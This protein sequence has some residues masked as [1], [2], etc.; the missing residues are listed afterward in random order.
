[1]SEIKFGE[2]C[3][4]DDKRDA[5]HVAVIPAIADEAL[6]PGEKVCHRYQYNVGSPRSTEER[7]N[8][9]GFVDPFLKVT[10]QAGERFWLFMS[11]S[12]VKQLRHDWKDDNFPDSTEDDYDD[13][14][15]GCY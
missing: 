4:D 2:L 5:V 12:A 3:D 15:R 8:V 11:P 9:I 7:A 10:V 13:G 6:E 14:C 1:M